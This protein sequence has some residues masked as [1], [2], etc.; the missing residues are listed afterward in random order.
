MPVPRAMSSMLTRAL[1]VPNAAARRRLLS[2][3]TNASIDA[4]REAA[5]AQSR[6]KYVQPENIRGRVELIKEHWPRII[7]RI[8]PQLVTAS[9]AAQMLKDAGGPYHPSMLDIDQ[10]KLKLTYFQAQTIRSRYTM[11][12]TLQELG[13]FADV[14]ESLFAPGGYWHDHP[15]AD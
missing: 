6:A 3:V 4:I 12:D 2:S 13:V 11:F 15:T 14:V 1:P 9:E 8:T 10:E 7:E 5:L